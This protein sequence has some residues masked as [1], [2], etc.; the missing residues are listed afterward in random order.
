MKELVAPFDDIPC[1][2]RWKEEERSWV[3]NTRNDIGRRGLHCDC[4][5]WGSGGDALCSIRSVKERKKAR[6][7]LHTALFRGI[8]WRL[9]KCLLRRYPTS[10][11]AA[12]A[13]PPPDRKSASSNPQNAERG[14]QAKREGE[15]ERWPKC[16]KILS[17]ALSLSLRC[18]CRQPASLSPSLLLSPAPLTCPR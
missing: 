9:R 15:R 1:H 8:C 18:R 14:K 4:T 7:N 5:D 3:Q 2:L 16:N 6:F 17:P 10:A 13:V 12:P 11:Y